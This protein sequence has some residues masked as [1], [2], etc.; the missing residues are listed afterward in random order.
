MRD[1][2]EQSEGVFEALGLSSLEERVY[3]AILQEPGISPTVLAGSARLTRDRVSKAL[4]SLEERGLV[5]RISGRKVRFAPAPPD[6]AIELLILKQQEALERA[7][8]AAGELTK[9]FRAKQE[10]VSPLEIVE[11]IRGRNAVG[12]RANQLV[13]GSEHEQLIFDKPPFARSLED[14]ER[15]EVA[16]LK[17]G[18]RIGAIYDRESLDLPGTLD[19]IRSCTA[20][21]EEARVS[22]QRL[23]MKLLIVDRRVALVPL[24][25][26]IPG[27]EGALLVH[28]SPLLDALIELFEKTWETSAPASF[29]RRDD[30]HDFATVSVEEQKYLM[31]LTAG[32][33][34]D[35]IARQLEISSS[36][37]KRRLRELMNRL[38]ARTRFQAGLLACRRGWIDDEPS[39]DGFQP[40]TEAGAPPAH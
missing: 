39:A 25:S 26:E 37:V 8:L 21:G 18:V 36:T 33:K 9:A 2:D 24:L 28:E 11:V 27:T 40:R 31:L 10:T 23:P 15:D 12:E 13:L 1:Q 30:S 3:Q 14:S 6:T 17:Q 38:G 29:D 32:F 7:R 22:P 20:A 16:L 5:A 34:D 35:A 19:H 4:A